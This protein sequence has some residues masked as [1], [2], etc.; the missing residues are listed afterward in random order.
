MIEYLHI[1][2]LSHYAVHTKESLG[3]LESEISTFWKILKAPFITNRLIDHKWQTTQK[4]HYFWHYADSVREKGAFPSYRTDRTEIWHKPLNSA[5]R[6]SNKGS[7]VYHFILTEQTR[8]AVF[9]SMV[10]DMEYDDSDSDSVL[11]RASAS[12]IRWI[13]RLF[14]DSI[15]PAKRHRRLQS[16]EC[17]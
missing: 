7:D 1:H 4:V 9:H 2:H 3:W 12:W 11:N 13:H 14:L 15:R 16:K 6:R 8:L 5:F 10:D 17:Q